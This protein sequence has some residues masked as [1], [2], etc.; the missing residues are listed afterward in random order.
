MTDNAKSQFPAISDVPGAVPRSAAPVTNPEPPALVRNGGPAASFAWDEFIYG[1]L[2][3]PH[4]RRNY[5]HAVTRFLQSCSHRNIELN[6]I[7]PRDVGVYLDALP[8]A[9]ATKKLHLAALRHFFDQLVNR[10]V[11]LLNPAASVRGER[12]Q[13][14]EGRTPEITPQ[15]ARRLLHSIN[16][17]HVVGL[18]DRAIVGILIYTAALVGAVSRL[19][20]GDFCD[21]GDQC[22]LRFSI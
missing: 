7:T 16:L 9:P 10:H 19:R 5:R 1:R 2:R 13:V 18:R 3:N 11:I 4:T 22:C 6:T 20:R 14:V 15:Q 21:T 17:S 12:L 8:F